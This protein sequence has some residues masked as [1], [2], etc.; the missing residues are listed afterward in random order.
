MAIAKL[1]IDFEAR[2]GQFET[3]LKRITSVA[4]GVS[5]KLSSAFK[6]VGLAMAGIGAGVGLSSLKSQFDGAIAAASGLKE[7]A[8]KTG[9]SVENLS[10]L[11]AVAKITATDMGLVESAMNKLSKGLHASDDDAKGTGKALEFL[12]LKLKDLRGKDSAEN[13]KLVADKMA[14][15]EDGTGKVAVSMALF[16]KNGAEM[17]SFMKDLAGSGD[18]VVKTTEAQAV[19]AKNYEEDLR[20]LSAT[21]QALYKVVSL[22]LAPAFDTFVRALIGAKDE[23]NGMIKTGKDL[24]ADGSIREWGLQAVAVAGFIVDAFDGVARTV[25]LIGITIGAAAAQAA[26]LASGNFGE[27]KSI[28]SEWQ[29]DRDELLN[30]PLFSQKLQVQTDALR[31]H[32]AQVE[33][34]KKAYASFP[35]GVQDKAL[36]S[37]EESFYGSAGG[38][39]SASGFTAAADPRNAKSAASAAKV[40]DYTKLIQSLNEKIAVEQLEIDTLGQASKAEKDYAKYQA[41]IASGAVKLSGAQKSVVD[42]YYQIYIARSKEKEF[43]DLVD[44]QTEAVRLQNVAMQD[45]V[46]QI[47]KETELYGLT[48]SQISVVEQ[49]R[50]RDALAMAKENNAGE[51]HIASLEKELRLRGNISDALIRKDQKKNE[52]DEAADKVRNSLDAMSEFSKQA[53]RNMQDAFAD[54]LFDPFAK[55]TK[56][57]LKGFGETIQKMIAQAASAQLLKTL[58]GDMGNTGTVGGLA[59][60]GLNW[61]KGAVGGFGTSSA[62]ASG[63]AFTA[64]D[65]AWLK[66]P[67][68]N[69]GIMTSAGPLSLSKYAGGGVANRPQLALFGE[70]RTPEAYVPLPDGRRIPVAMS[71][72]GGGQV[73]QNLHFHGAAEPA[74][75]K[76]AAAA[77]ARSVLGVANGARRYG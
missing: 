38:T 13:L 73:V 36:K 64:A 77:G 14:E 70:G 50:L 19:A 35:K 61:L 12:G 34:V 18:L 6:G 2:L 4:D 22:E 53:A 55:G 21:K 27:Y 3:E 65:L 68:A 15:L 63:T 7:M 37:L 74:Q 66:A 69:G 76:R 9:A 1:S 8:D 42:T 26:A 43:A 32:W 49:A 31:A 59:G 41:D 28:R 45:R 5:S 48:E 23:T 75:V 11:G 39:K 71:G 29:A 10:G 51:D 60:Q 62:T 46:R 47:D 56:E 44:K 33:A 24:A 67:F 17:L 16:G 40:D 52:I 58:F 72:G 25:K 57:M 30:K 20:R 54:F